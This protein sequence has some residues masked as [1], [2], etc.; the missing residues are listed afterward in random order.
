[1]VPRISVFICLML[2]FAGIAK[3]AIKIE[4]PAAGTIAVY[5]CNGPEPEVVFLYMQP[6]LEQYWFVKHSED[7]GF[8][9][10]SRGQPVDIH[11]LGYTQQISLYQYENEEP[12]SIKRSGLPDKLE[13]GSE[14][15]SVKTYDLSGYEMISILSVAEEVTEATFENRKVKVVKLNRAFKR[16]VVGVDKVSA[17][18]TFFSDYSPDLKLPLR[19]GYRPKG[20]QHNVNYGI[21]CDLQQLSNVREYK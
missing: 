20:G 18:G 16:K 11:T 3:A 5:K 12:R 21:S 1:M 4:W 10:F 19:Y 15:T 9:K 17:E 2:L 8:T 7:S 6:L 13:L 14:H